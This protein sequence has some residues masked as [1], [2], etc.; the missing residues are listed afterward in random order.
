[1][2]YEIHDRPVN[3][4]ISIAFTFVNREEIVT[5]YKCGIWTGKTFR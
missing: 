1:M 2:E 3:T 4:L 5:I